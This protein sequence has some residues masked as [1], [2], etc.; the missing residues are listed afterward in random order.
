MSSTRKRKNDYAAKRLAKRMDD[1]R[2]RR[3]SKKEEKERETLR[4]LI[5][6][7]PE[8]GLARIEAVQEELPGEEIQLEVICF[9]RRPATDQSAFCSNINCRVKEFHPACVGLR[10]E[11]DSTGQRWF[12]PTCELLLDMQQQMEVRNVIPNAGTCAMLSGM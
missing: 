7:Y 8:E 11:F 12:C 4:G 6:K 10:E 1:Q 3:Q 5:S 2:L 9:C